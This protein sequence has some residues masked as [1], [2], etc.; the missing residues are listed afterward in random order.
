MA[1]NTIINDPLYGF[2]SVD[3]PLIR[4]IINH[5]DFQRLRRI[6]QVGLA[7]L[8]YPGA[9]HNRFHHALGAMQLMTSALDILRQKGIEI[10]AEE[11]QAARIA[12]L[13]HDVGH[14]PFSHAL[15]YTLLK[16]V[17]HE[18]ISLLI[19]KKLNSSLNGRLDLCI[20]IFE[21]TY[22][23]KFF[24]ELISGQLDM[25]RLDY[26]NRDR[27]FTGVLEGTVGAE[28]IIQMLYVHDDQLVIEEKGI[29]SIENFLSARR[30]MYWQVYLHKTSVGAEKLL[31]AILER[32]RDIYSDDI[33]K[34][35]SPSLQYFLKHR[36]KKEDME[37]SEILSLFT[38]MD[39][40]DV[41]SAIKSWKSCNDFVL[42]KLSRQF[43]ERQLYKVMISKEPFS[44]QQISSL[45][46]KCR[47]LYGLGDDELKYFIDYGAITNSAYV[48]ENRMIK[49]Y[50]KDGSLIDVAEASDLPNIKAMSKV[51][52]KYYICFPKEL[53]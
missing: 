25:D 5:P 27:F 12:I 44:A 6:K 49:I 22:H 29:Y 52:K 40:I 37:S 11:Y 43:L 24:H 31:I 18:D 10:S 2:I 9:V 13:L 41:W 14:G 51:V 28:R 1:A 47:Q 53:I 20:A 46:N 48:S 15:E 17:D 42:S 33:T 16:R 39:D 3:D 7:E 19:M 36:L 8:V 21:N 32:A 34:Y 45:E 35:V 38:D 50:R 4:S 26:L 30:L 23:R